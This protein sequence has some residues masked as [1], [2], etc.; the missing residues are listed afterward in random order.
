MRGHSPRRFRL[1]VAIKLFV[2]LLA[3]AVLPGGLVAWWATSSMEKSRLDS[4]AESME[5]LAAARADS[6]D[7]FIHFRRNN[8]ER[9]ASIMADPLG[10]YL[11]AA[12]STADV[13]RLPALQD[14]EALDENGEPAT[15]SDSDSDSI[16]DSDSD[17]GEGA[18]IDT[19]EPE[20][21][22]LP[23][24]RNSV[25]ESL[26]QLRRNLAMILW[27][28]SEF[29]ELLIIGSE[30]RVLVST[31]EGHENRDASSIDYFM[32]G[33]RGTFVQ[34]VFYS[35]ITQRPTMVVSTPIYSTD[36][37]ALGVLAA[38][39]NLERFF[40]LLNDMVGMGETGE[41]VAVRQVGDQ[42]I[43]QAPTRHD[44]DASQKVLPAYAEP[45]LR[46]ARGE[47][48]SG[49]SKDLRNVT[50]VAGWRH[51]PELGWGIVAKVDREEVLRPVD[52]L[53]RSLGYALAAILLTAALCALLVAGGIVR[54]LRQLRAATDRI[55]KGDMA[56]HLDIRSNDEVGDLAESFERMI[57]AIRF[58]RER[59]GN[60]REDTQALVQKARE[61]DEALQREIEAERRAQEGEDPSR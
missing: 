22:T 25:R 59:A 12:R 46:S 13:A 33:L 57:A 60:G 29:E 19:D 41:T 50:V 52:D 21:V 1:T 47:S 20:A 61:E 56:V 43:I 36:H 39:L 2:L 40:T 37:E 11:D 23:P 27:D 54:P 7:R 28:R 51:L 8:V 32:Q 31:F 10:I 48:G 9:I 45:G 49:V 58:F 55:S 3:F 16:S 17:S 15:D 53:R 35:P 24:E 5:A 14:A 18:E 30:G 26:D 44:P 38:R 4:A 34:P 6:V 42:V